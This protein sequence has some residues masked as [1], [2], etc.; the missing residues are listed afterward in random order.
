MSG[1]LSIID[2]CDGDRLDGPRGP[3]A[4]FATPANDYIR[5]RALAV[6]QEADRKRRLAPARL[7][8]SA[9]ARDKAVFRNNAHDVGAI[10]VEHGEGV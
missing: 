3:H 5:G 9:F 4:G 6:L 1:L 8:A 10:G 2:F 7:D